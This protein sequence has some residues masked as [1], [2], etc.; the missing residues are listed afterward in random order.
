MDAPKEQL[1]MAPSE[2]VMKP[3]HKEPP[4]QSLVAV[5]VPEKA[6]LTLRQGVVMAVILGPP[7]SLAPYRGGGWSS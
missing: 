2:V 7:R 5:V 6:K 4:A 1:E 3:G